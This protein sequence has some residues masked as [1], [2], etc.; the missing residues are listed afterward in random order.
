MAIAYGMIFT[1]PGV[2]F[3]YYG[4]EIG[5]R[6]LNLPTKEGGYYRTGSRTPMQW[7]RGKNLGFSP[8]EAGSLY[9]P[10]DASS[11]APTVQAAKDDP[12]SLLNVVK[13]LLRLRNG[14]KDLQAQPN[15]KIIYAEKG[16]LPFIYRRGNFLIALNP[17]GEKAE[18]DLSRL[19]INKPEEVFTIGLCAIKDKICAMEGQSFGIWRV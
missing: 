2:P 4:D 13:K 10:V 5:M 11:D 3:L 16:K 14:E 18:K 17:G 1:M 9:L 15:L 6:Y 19:A 7:D 12:A 8:A